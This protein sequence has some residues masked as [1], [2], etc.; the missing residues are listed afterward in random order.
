MAE[1]QKLY[2][3]EIRLLQDELLHLI[4]SFFLTSPDHELIWKC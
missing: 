4:K 3:T 1:Q 2:H